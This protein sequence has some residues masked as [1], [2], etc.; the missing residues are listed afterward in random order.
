M[1]MVMSMLAV[2]VFEDAPPLEVAIVVVIAA[3][4]AWAMWI[5][6]RS[7]KNP[8]PGRERAGEGD[9]LSA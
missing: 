7:G 5:G 2:R 6:A 1:K 4:F 9:S 8:P 3:I